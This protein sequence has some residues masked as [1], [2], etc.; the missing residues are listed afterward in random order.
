MALAGG[1]WSRFRAQ[2]R[3]PYTS[4]TGGAAS[5]TPLLGPQTSGLQPYTRTTTYAGGV[6]TG[7]GFGRRAAPTAGPTVDPA[8]MSA[9]QKAI[10]HYQP[11]GGF[12]KGTEAALERGRKKAVTSGAQSLVSAGLGGTTMGA[13]LG[14]KYEEEVAAPM[15]ARV[16][17]TRAE[18]ISG[19]EMAKARIIQSTTEA[20]RSRALQEY[21][22][23]LQQSTSM[24][25]T[26]MRQPTSIA[27]TR[28]PTTTPQRDTGGYG[29]SY[30]GTGQS[31]SGGGGGYSP[32]AAA[33]YGLYPGGYKGLS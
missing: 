16:E 5:R 23:K 11:G 3:S 15:R 33:G 27:P 1:Y 29:A 28:I 6:T 22:A 8:A 32:Y 17:E 7:A 30:G 13:G 26:A 20:G 18:A 12:G 21:L 14:K 9:M 10:A 24:S 31:Y 19:L 4:L 25:L 2:A